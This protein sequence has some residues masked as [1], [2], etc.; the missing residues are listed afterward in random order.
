MYQLI[1]TFWATL[2]KYLH[3]HLTLSE[4]G[5]KFLW[6]IV[7]IVLPLILAFLSVKY[8]KR[9]LDVLKTNWAYHLRIVLLS[10]AFVFNILRFTLITLSIRIYVLEAVV[11]L[12]ILI[13]LIV[14][15]KEFKKSL[16]FLGENILISYGCVVISFVIEYAFREKAYP[17]AILIAYFCW[18]YFLF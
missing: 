3:N 15:T 9:H 1:F 14:E 10:L 12:S 5:Y 17:F 7:F 16:I 13:K 18:S 2:E 8:A 6:V 4:F 11:I